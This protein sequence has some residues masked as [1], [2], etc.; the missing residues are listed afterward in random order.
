MDISDQV[1]VKNKLCT[2][3]EIALALGITERAAL[4]RAT[5]EAWPFEERDGRGRGG[6]VKLFAFDKLPEEVQTAIMI[7]EHRRMMEVWGQQGAGGNG[8][9]AKGRKALPPIG[10]DKALI[11]PGEVMPPECS[12]NGNRLPARGFTGDYGPVQ[13]IPG[14]A[15]G[16]TK[17]EIDEG[18][19]SG[20]LINHYRKFMEGRELGYGLKDKAREAFVTAYNLGERGSYPGIF[21]KVG[22]I[23]V[24]KVQRWDAEMRANGNDPLVLCDRRGKHRAGAI[25]VT[26]DQQR[27]LRDC[28]LSYNRPLVS[29]IIRLARKAFEYYEIP[30]PQ[31]DDT[32]RRWLA[33]FKKYYYAEWVLYREGEKALNDKCVFH[34]QRDYDRIQVGDVALADGHVTNWDIVNP[35]TGREQ[36]M[37]WICWYDMKSNYVMGWELMPTENTQAIASGLYRAILMLGKIPKIAYL[38]NG[39]AFRAKFFTKVA[40]FEDDPITGLFQRLGMINVHHQAYHAES[41]TVEVVNKRIGELERMAPSFCGESIENKPAWRNRDEKVAKQMHQAMTGGRGV[42]LEESHQAIAGF[43]D[44]YHERPQDG[45]LKGRCP[46]E[47]FEEGRG[48]GFC[49][50]QLAELR[51]LM[52]SMEFKKVHRDGLKFPWSDQRYY[53]PDLYGRQQQSVVVRYDWNDRSRVYV[54][55]P[56]GDFICEAELKNKTHPMARL[57][58]NDADVEE[59]KNQSELKGSLVKKTKGPARQ[60]LEEHVMPELRRQREQ[61]G[62]DGAGSEQASKVTPLRRKGEVDLTITDEEQARYEQ[63]IAEAEAEHADYEAR[64]A[65]RARE[66]E[67]AERA[68]IEQECAE[69]VKEVSARETRKP[70]IWEELR[71]LPDSDRYEKDL[72]YEARGMLMPRSERAWMYSYFEKSEYFEQHQIYF[73]EIRVKMALMWQGCEGVGRHRKEVRND[74][75]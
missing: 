48:P 65:E 7:H 8:D 46:R 12:A 10:E 3:K 28:A 36:R 32:F 44:E 26:P 75:L 70:T 21:A 25:T 23:S 1:R 45:H 57:L 43:L 18:L 53:H 11:I 41:A 68:R 39:R 14:V 13:P 55:E 34:M 58:G 69:A 73:E 67:A 24:Q 38:D 6:K 60:F 63:E 47:V 31:S 42:T 64:K 52:M 61:I 59:L 74:D 40:K 54:Y 56:G 33:W 15:V 4:K 27:I 72:E 9:G 19:V 20:L 29:E 62:F 2:I 5:K 49:P 16:F 17:D 30:H 22:P 71:D 37:V 50:E 66:A 51:V 35:W